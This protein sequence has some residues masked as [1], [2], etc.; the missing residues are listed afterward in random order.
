MVMLADRRQTGG[1][2]S[3]YSVL[4]SLCHDTRV[5]ILL[6]HPSHPRASCKRRL[7]TGQRIANSSSSSSSLVFAPLPSLLERNNGRT[8]ALVSLL[9]LNLMHVQSAAFAT[10]PR[11]RGAKKDGLENKGEERGRRSSDERG[12]RL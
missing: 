4:S 6:L 1:M 5:S 10:H 8:L 9:P 2:R 11:D 7:L 3:R 12:E